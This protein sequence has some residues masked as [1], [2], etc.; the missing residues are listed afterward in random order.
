MKVIP[1]PATGSQR[2]S[3]DSYTGLGVA[4]DYDLEGNFWVIHA[5]S[6]L[7]NYSNKLYQEFRFMNYRMVIA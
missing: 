5:N 6:R 7:H 1:S 4:E 3:D 2:V